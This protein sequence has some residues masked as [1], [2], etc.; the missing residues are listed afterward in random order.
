M[1][2]AINFIKMQ[3]SASSRSFIAN[4][5]QVS[6]GEEDRSFQPSQFCIRVLR[7]VLG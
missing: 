5:T 7:K 3:P 1:D 6:L 4:D 2:F